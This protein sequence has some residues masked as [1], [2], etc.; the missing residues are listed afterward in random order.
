LPIDTGRRRV[1]LVRGKIVDNLVGV[2][3]SVTAGRLPSL[4][5]WSDRQPVPERTEKTSM[6]SA[7]AVRRKEDDVGDTGPWTLP[8]LPASVG[9]ARR[10]VRSAL[11]S[12]ELD[13]DTDVAL[14]LVS[15]VVTNAVL[16]A[17][18][19]VLLELRPTSGRLWV[20]VTDE[21]AAKPRVNSY[22][23]EAATGRGMRLLDTL[24]RTWGVD[25]G[26]DGGKRV[27]FEVGRDQARRTNAFDVTWLGGAE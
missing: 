10:L 3:R 24:A 11:A 21:S 20:G 14:L 5:G 17:R 6:V 9:R 18:S 15:E 26:V 23:V 1:E 2:A 8:G 22:T 7:A 4:L 12:A 25:Q 13:V 16:H 19:D 27:W